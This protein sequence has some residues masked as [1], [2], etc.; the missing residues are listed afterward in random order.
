MRRRRRRDAAQHGVRV[1]RD[2][3]WC[4]WAGDIGWRADWALRPMSIERIAIFLGLL[5]IAS[6]VWFC[7]EFCIRFAAL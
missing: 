1:D 2:R 5:T 4:G 7:V 6:A 3:G